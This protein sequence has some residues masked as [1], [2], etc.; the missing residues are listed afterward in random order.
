MLLA[1]TLIQ[2]GDCK[3]SVQGMGKPPENTPEHLALTATRVR[4]GQ[5]TKG[6]MTRRL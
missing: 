5:G 3:A 6:P 4:C 1:G 2:Q